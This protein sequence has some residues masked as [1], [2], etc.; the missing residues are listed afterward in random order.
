MSEPKPRF[1]PV[2]SKAV[3]E[4]S[5]ASV[6]IDDVEPPYKPVNVSININS[7]TIIY[8]FKI[9][10]MTCVACSQ[11]IESAMK[12]EFGD[13]GCISVVIALLTHK[14]RMEFEDLKSSELEIS[15]EKIIEEVENIGFGAE[16]LETIINNQRALRNDSL[17]DDIDDD[18]KL[19]RQDANV[20]KVCTIIISGMTCASCQQCI[21]SHLKGMPGIQKATV[22]LLTHKGTIQY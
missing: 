5:F 17:K 11:T 4:S 20:I 8:E 6:S 15:P 1:K 21:E 14:M 3:K 7:S 9:D 16:L 13:K 19:Q 10:G 22:S 18:E 12:K 2:S